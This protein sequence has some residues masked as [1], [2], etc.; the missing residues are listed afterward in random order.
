MTTDTP[1]VPLTCGCKCGKV[2]FNAAD[3]ASQYALETT[4]AG[5]M[6]ALPRCS[7]AQE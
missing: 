4:T 6:A 5:S 1:F 7:T 2:R 3:A